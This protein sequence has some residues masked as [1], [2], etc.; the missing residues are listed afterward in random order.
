MLHVQVV[1]VCLTEPWGIKYVH[2][3]ANVTVWC[4]VVSDYYGTC[5]AYFVLCNAC[6][7]EGDARSSDAHAAVSTGINPETVRRRIIEDYKEKARRA[8]FQR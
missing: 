4:V 8:L 2:R 3:Q 1:K 7:H 6:A 5:Q